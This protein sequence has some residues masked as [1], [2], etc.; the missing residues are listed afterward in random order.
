MKEQKAITLVKC[1]AEPAHATPSIFMILELSE[2]VEEENEREK[3]RSR[4]G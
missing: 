4:K 1:V 3:S 2:V